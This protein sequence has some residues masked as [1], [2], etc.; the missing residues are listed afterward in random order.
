MSTI[1]F[2]NKRNYSKASIGHY[3]NHLLPFR[4]SSKP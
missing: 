3:K 2:K 4:K 1:A